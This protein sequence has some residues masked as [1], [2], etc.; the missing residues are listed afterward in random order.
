MQKYIYV[1]YFFVC[2]CQFYPLSFHPAM[3]DNFETELISNPL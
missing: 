1:K 2:V 3:L